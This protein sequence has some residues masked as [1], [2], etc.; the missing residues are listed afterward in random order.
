MNRAKFTDWLRSQTYRDDPV[1]D[2]ARDLTADP[3]GPA[4]D[5]PVTVL[6]YVA[7]VGGTAAA[8]ACRAAVAEWGAAL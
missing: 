3:V 8:T 5:H 7:T 6:D 4:D 1:G 2:I